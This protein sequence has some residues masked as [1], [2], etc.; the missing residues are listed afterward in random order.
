M[1]EIICGQ[2]LMSVIDTCLVYICYAGLDKICDVTTVG[3]NTSFTRSAIGK[4]VIAIGKVIKA[5]RTQVFGEV[6]LYVDGDSRVI[7][8]GTSTSDLLIYR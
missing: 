1:G 7:C 3:Q 2:A 5:G 4:Y 6:S 8:S